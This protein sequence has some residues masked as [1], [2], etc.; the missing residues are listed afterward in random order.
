MNSMASGIMNTNLGNVQIDKEVIAKYAGSSAVECFGIVG[1]ATVSVKDGFAKLLKR[2][3]LSQEQKEEYI[4]IIEEESIR[5]SDMA[6]KVL[7]LT[8]V[9]NQSILT[10]VSQ[11]N[12]SEQIRNCVL[13]LESKWSKKN[14]EFD[15]DFPEIEVKAN[16]EMLKQVWINLID[17]AIKFSHANSVIE[18]SITQKE[19][20]KGTVS[21]CITNVGEEIP[22]NE[23]KLIFRKFYQSDKSHYSYG[24][25]IGLAIVKKIVDLHGGEIKVESKNS[26]TSFIVAL[27]NI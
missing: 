7:N 5:L 9:E 19:G 27:K 16:E 1:M 20:K 22:E 14:V 15:M 17:N 3:N 8:K 11:Y 18:I 12:L 13:L 25:G 6:T 4:S 2:G 23:Q 21:V 26:K 24:N 10:D